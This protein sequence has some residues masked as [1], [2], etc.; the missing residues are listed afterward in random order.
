MRRWL[1]KLRKEKSYTQQEVASNVHIDRA[2]YAQ[3]ENGTRNPSIYVAK[4]IAAFFNINPSTFFMEH[5]S[6]PFQVAIANSPIIVAH[7]GLDLRYTWIFNPHKD[8]DPGFIMGK[9]DDELANNDGTVAL[10][11]LKEQ[12]IKENKPMR[13]QIQ[14]PLSDGLVT[15]D[16]FAQPILDNHGN[17]IGVAST[18]SLLP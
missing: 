17:V 9:R 7:N 2:Y 5:I 1:I 16:I 3:I 12:T 10:M 6:D 8:F 14:F 13:R 15:Y 18:L 11:K 4:Q